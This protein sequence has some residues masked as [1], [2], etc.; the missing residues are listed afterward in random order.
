MPSD[1]EFLPLTYK[2]REL[3]EEIRS[4]CELYSKSP[5]SEMSFESIYCWSAGEHAE[6]CIIDEG[7]VIVYN[8][9]D[10]TSAFY[11]PLVKRKEYFVPV[12]NKI[13]EYCWLHNYDIYIERLTKEMS[14]LL[15][16]WDCTKC[17][18]FAV[19]GDFEYLY[20]PDDLIELDGKKYK[21][22]RNFFNG[23]VD[24]YNYEFVG[25][26]ECET[27]DD[28]AEFK[29]GIL[30]LV[31][32][33]GKDPASHDFQIERSAIERAMDEFEELNLF[34]D[35]IK[36]DGRVIALSIGFVSKANV[37]VCMFE[38]ADTDYRGS[39]AAI[40]QFV[41]KKRFENCEFINR[42]EDMGVPGLRKAKMSYHPTAFSEKFIITDRPETIPEELLTYDCDGDSIE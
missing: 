14:E 6:R 17:E 3:F 38:K 30:E 24:D 32:Y 11:P 34:C 12:V 1:F 41:A 21:S 16:D 10:N 35:A 33:C 13:A 19:R 4:S 20:K 31:D 40:N 37:G 23:F 22:K 26:D 27:E 15:T 2:D 9:P 36:V 25:L 39:Y 28:R 7:V 8:Y 29:K 42:Q 18:S 5:A